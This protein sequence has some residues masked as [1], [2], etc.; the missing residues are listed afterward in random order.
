MGLGLL[1][2]LGAQAGMWAAPMAGNTSGTGLSMAFQGSLGVANG[3]A[4]EHVFDYE[5]RGQSRRQLSRLDWDLKNVAMGGGSLSVRLWDRLALNGGLW[6]ALSEG[7]GEMDDYDWLDVRSS[8]WTHYSLSDV[9][10]TEGYL[11]DVNAAWK[12]MQMH[13]FSTHVLVGYKQDGWTWEDRGVYLLYP[14]F[15][16]VPYPLDGENMILYEQEFR[17]PY[18][19]ANVDWSRGAFTLSGYVKWSPIVEGTD[20]D[21]HVAREM[22]FKET[23]E[24][25]DM[26]GLGAEARYEFAQGTFQGVYVSAAV[27][28]Q[29]IDRMIG[30]MVIRDEATGQSGV[31]TDAAGVENRYWMISLG[32]GLRF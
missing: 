5:S 25:G 20:W 27:D 32:G 28:Y 30:D 8:E 19:G 12:L 3:E 15:G 10:V 31:E 23:F 18:L 29:Q 24:G 22:S 1:L 9:D 21:E 11:L 26:L 7:S 13:G 2:P 17:M 4:K 16:Y 14:E 6:L